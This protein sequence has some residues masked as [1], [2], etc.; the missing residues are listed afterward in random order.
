MS[1]RPSIVGFLVVILSVTTAATSTDRTSLHPAPERHRLIVPPAATFPEESGLPAGIRKFFGIRPTTDQLRFVDTTIDRLGHRQTMLRQEFLGIPVI[2]GELRVHQRPDQSIRAVNGL[3]VPSITVGTTPRVSAT[4]AK[5]IAFDLVARTTPDLDLPRLEAHR[6]KLAIL[7]TGI[8]RDIPGIDHL[9]WVVEVSDGR[10]IRQFLYLDAHTGKP[11]DRISGIAN[12]YREVHQWNLD[13]TVWREGDDLPYEESDPDNAVEVNELILGSLDVHT[14]FT[15][16]SGGDYRSWDG[17][18][19]AMHSVQDF[20]YEDC[21]NAFWSG[22]AAFFC[23]GMAVDDIVSHEW[24][25]AYT[26]ATDA[27]IYR[28]QPGALNEA[29]SDI[30]GEIADRLN[31]RGTD[32]PDTR[33]TDGACW[34]NGT[35]VRWLI[36]EDST[37]GAFRD[38]WSP[39][40]SGDPNRV[41]SELYACGEADDG[42]VHTNSG[43]P[44]HAFALTVDGGGFNGVE[45]PGIGL[46]R[47]AHVWWRA[48]RYYQIPA[49]DFA[50]HADLIGLACEDLIG[51]QLTDLVT[52]APTDITIAPIHCE[53]I[54]RAMTAVEMRLPPAQC[55]FKPL[56]VGPP[57]SFPGGRTLFDE[58]FSSNPLGDGGWRVS[59]VGVHP[60]YRSRDWARVA[61]PPAGSDGNGAM[62]AVD[63][64][65]IGDCIPGSDDQSGVMYLDTPPI[66]LPADSREIFLVLDHYVATEAGWDGGVITISVDGG[67]FRNLFLNAFR[68]NPYNGTLE[69]ASDG[70]DNP[71]AGLQAFTGADEGSVRG[72][73]GQT[74]V[75]LENAVGS[76]R[77]IVIRFSFGVDGCNGLDGWYLDRVRL[78][79]D[80]PEPRQGSG[81]AG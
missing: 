43:I 50:A 32:E 33:R 49:T 52:G 81:R 25:H 58:D 5:A 15:N 70:N 53:A 55:E 17:L 12:I 14:L 60:E 18:D 65:F 26:M 6:P 64:I 74:Q 37:L 34:S 72:S 54:E 76:G 48:M 56:L 36:G 69:T 7:R 28:Y 19:A 10:A 47:A 61:E 51:T 57:P 4:E 21:P 67:P 42:G 9:V 62:Y 16:L 1:S 22:R 59:N 45:V 66:E 78:I 46:T 73:W 23:K 13:R 77:T 40:C 2:G 44:N 20:R 24:T 38:M 30:F 41:S 8:A 63:S 31:G 68:F 11:V 39:H 3:F 75:S 79:E 80:G 29:T 35:S 27:L 71:L